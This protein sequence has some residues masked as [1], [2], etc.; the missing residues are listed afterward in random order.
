VKH[1]RYSALTVSGEL[2]SGELQA[3]DTSAALGHLHAQALLPIDAR[4][5]TEE[6][7]RQFRVGVRSARSL[8][9]RELALASQQLARLLKAGLPLD[10]AL[11]ILIGLAEGRQMTAALQQVLDRLRDGAALADAFASQGAAF[12]ETYVTLVRAGELSGALQAVLAETAGL[13]MRSEAMRQRAISAMIYP[14][15][16]IVVACLSLGVILT[17][18]LPQFEPMFREAGAKLPT[19]TR[20]VMSAGHM[21]EGNFWFLLGFVAAAV[22]LYRFAKR[23]PAVALQQDRILLACPLIGGMI[24]RFE[25]GRFCRTLGVMLGN[26]VAAPIAMALSA[27]TIGNRPIAAAVEECATRFKEGEG[28]SAPLSATGR[29]PDLAIQLIRIGEE[30]GRLDEML[31]EVAGVYDQDVQRALERLLAI[32]VPVLTI[33]MGLL[34]AFIVAAVMMALLTVNDLAV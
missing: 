24:T 7:R 20:I 1:F 30:T 8:P 15:I 4:E 33:G 21:L 5:L 2:V 26:G 11:N 18:V 25:V 14:V 3:L 29:F 34:I 22:C 19:S 28:L 16:L 10:R 32:L 6:A 17:A 31:G 9:I 13:L 23:K 27:G 12:P